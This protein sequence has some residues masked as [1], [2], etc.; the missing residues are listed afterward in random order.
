MQSAERTIVIDLPA[1]EVFDYVSDGTKAREWRPGVLDIARVST[2]AVGVGTVYRQGVFGPMG[3]RI[4]A[5]YEI[6]AFEPNTRLEFRA[7]AGPVRP[8]GGYRLSA[9]P[10]GKTAV[11]FWLR[12]DLSGWK[13]IVL[14][15]S[16]QA[17]MDAEM[18]ALD[19]LKAVLESR[20]KP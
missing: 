15:R 6:T 16:V 9:T 19:K 10:D 12:E 18:Q 20:A 4:A 7:I 3:R 5:D 2:D 17:S 13:R 1:A 8:Q 14:G 11:T